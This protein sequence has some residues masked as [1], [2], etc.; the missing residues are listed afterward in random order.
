MNILIVADESWVITDVEAAL[1]ESRYRITDTSNPHDV[2]NACTD[3]QADV[4]IADLQ[5]GTMGGMAVVRD[6]RAAVGAG[7]LPPTATVLLLDRAADAFISGRSGADGW[8]RKPFGAFELR[9]LLDEL[10]P[11]AAD[12]GVDSE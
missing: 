11:A 2:V 6:I 1:G 7:D 10:A 5:V 4:V 9:D 12:A 3:A 8:L